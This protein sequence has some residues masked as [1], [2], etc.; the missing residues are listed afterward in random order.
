MAEVIR[1]PAKQDTREEALTRLAH[2]ILV[3]MAVAFY[4]RDIMDVPVQAF[5]RDMTRNL[6]R[7][8]RVSNVELLDSMGS[9]PYILA[10]VEHMFLRALID[11][12]HLPAD[13]KI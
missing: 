4:E 7:D 13:Y 6:V 1:F 9:D 12:G 8:E 2:R 11:R 3:H 10:R 5:V